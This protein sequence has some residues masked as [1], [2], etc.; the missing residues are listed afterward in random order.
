M[1]ASLHFAFPWKAN[2]N[3][4][5]WRYQLTAR[6]KLSV[7]TPKPLPDDVDKLNMRGSMLGAAYHDKYDKLPRNKLVQTLFEATQLK[8]SSLR[9]QVPVPLN[10]CFNLL[11]LNV[12]SSAC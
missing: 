12:P 1:K 3:P 4:E 10:L 2:G 8:E 11:F 7:Y 5:S 9:L 6:T